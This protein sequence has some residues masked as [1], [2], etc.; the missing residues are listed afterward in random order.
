MIEKISS[1]FKLH[2]L[3]IEVLFVLKAILFI[4]DAPDCI[5][6]RHT[7]GGGFY[8]INSV[9]LFLLTRANR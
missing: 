6:H 1:H 9:F 8:I 3:R 7:R 5:T 2:L 4:K